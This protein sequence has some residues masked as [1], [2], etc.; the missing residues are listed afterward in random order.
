MKKIILIIILNLC[1]IGPSLADDIS[2]FQ[3][4][5]FSLNESLLD[6]FTKKELISNWEYQKKTYT[7]TN[8]K[9]YKIVFSD[10]KYKPYD[11]IV[12]YTL[13]SD[14][15]FKIKSITGIRSSMDIQKC[16]KELISISDDF[17]KLFPNSSKK[18][19]GPI[20]KGSDPT[21]KSFENGIYFVLNNGDEAGISCIDYGKELLK[22]Q[23]F[24]SDHM[25]IFID[26]K[27]Y[28]TWLQTEAWK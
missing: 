26:T 27:K 28:A 3:I 23:S 7:F 14:E 16:R 10:K 15:L 22:K 13:R 12:L 9:Y 6:N 25:Q 20:K 8:N 19:Y 24:S 17:S 18:K 21:G 11:Q 1:L 2:D 4:G 5:N